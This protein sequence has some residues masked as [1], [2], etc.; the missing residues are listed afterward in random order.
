[1]CGFSKIERLYVVQAVESSCI[2]D[3]SLRSMN[4]EVGQGVDPH[5][6]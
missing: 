2:R 5:C 6:R 3:V 4:D 1:M